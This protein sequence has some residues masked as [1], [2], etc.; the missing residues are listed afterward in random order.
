MT[1]VCA[2]TGGVLS[3]VPSALAYSHGS[4]ETQNCYFAP[5]SGEEFVTEMLRLVNECHDK[6]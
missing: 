3:Y 2:N 5:G 4:Y 1:F 6:Y